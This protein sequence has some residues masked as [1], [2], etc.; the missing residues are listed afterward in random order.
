M[1]S[2][3]AA[4]FFSAKTFSFSPNSVPPEGNDEIVLL[5]KSKYVSAAPNACPFVS[6]TACVIRSVACFV[7]LTACFA[8]AFKT[9]I[10]LGSFAMVLVL[11]Q[12]NWKQLTAQLEFV[13]HMAR[14]V[15]RNND[16][17]KRR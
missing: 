15:E 17:M 4:M 7:S 11:L 12:L 6:S 5:R 16:I 14:Y 1:N 10:G 3:V 8:C 13:R 2:R 9:S